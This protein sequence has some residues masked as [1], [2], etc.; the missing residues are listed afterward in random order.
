MSDLKEYDELLE[1][2]NKWIEQCKTIY[3]SNIDISLFISTAI[4]GNDIEYYIPLNSQDII[5]ECDDIEKCKKILYKYPWFDKIIFK[6]L[7]NY[8]LQLF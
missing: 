4:K 5:V 2:Q 1:D 8:N 3:A 7:P 6:A